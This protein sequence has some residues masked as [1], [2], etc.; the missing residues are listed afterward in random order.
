MAYA[1][2]GENSRGTQLIVAL[3]DNLYLAGTVR[4]VRVCTCPCLNLHT[5]AFHLLHHRHHI[6]PPP[7]LTTTQTTP[8]PPHLTTITTQTTPHHH[9][10]PPPHRLPRRTTSGDCLSQLLAVVRHPSLH[11]PIYPALPFSH[12]SFLSSLYNHFFSLSRA[13]TQSPFLSPSR[14]L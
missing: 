1:G 14:T 4:T 10:S 3:E 12:L 9:T 11:Q 6:S 2:G 8:T 5:A 7:H 13:H